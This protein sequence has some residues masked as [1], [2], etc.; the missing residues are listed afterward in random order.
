MVENFF[1]FQSHLIKRDGIE[2]NSNLA[3]A[4]GRLLINSTTL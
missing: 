1:L 2:V 4:F 3:R